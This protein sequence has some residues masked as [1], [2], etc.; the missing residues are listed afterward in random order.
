MRELATYLLVLLA[1][2]V[3][4]CAVG[5]SRNEHPQ[6]TETT[7]QTDTLI[8]R[9]TVQVEK[10]VV[11]R[12]KITDTLLV[13]VHDTL[14]VNDTLYVTLPRELKVYSSDEYYA[15]ISGYRPSLDYIE[16]YQKTTTISK[17]E[18]VKEKKNSIAF[19]VEA[20][21]CITPSVPIYLEYSRSLHKNVELNAGVFRDLVLNENGFKVGINAHIGW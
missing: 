18:T 5:Y 9:D 7:V 8:L 13:E 21:W 4:G 12:K 16:V 15:E 20:G 6:K 14:R 1:G 11:V 19:G 10:P 2:V 17:T 3:I